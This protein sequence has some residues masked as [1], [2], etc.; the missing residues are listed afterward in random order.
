MLIELILVL[1]FSLLIRLIFLVSKSDDDYVHLWNIYQRYK[2]KN[3]TNQDITNSV[4]DGKRGYPILHHY[5]VSLFPKKAWVVVAK[6]LN[7]TY[8]LVLIVFLYYVTNN[9]FQDK[10]LSGFTYGFWA[11][12]LFST[13]PVLFPV[14]A[15]LKAM[16][17]RVV[18]SLPVFFYLLLLFYFTETNNYLIFIPMFIFGVLIIL[19]SQFAFQFF[20]LFNIVFSIFTLNF[21]PLYILIFIL[22]LAFLFPKLGIKDIISFKIAHIKWYLKSQEGTSVEKRNKVI[23]IFLLPKYLFLNVKRFLKIVFYDNSY[24][25][26][27]LFFPLI[28]YLLVYYVFAIDIIKTPLI[29]YIDEL[30]LS[31]LIIFFLT[32]HRPLIILGEAERYLEFLSPFVSIYFVY[33]LNIG[34]E[35]MNNLMIFL[36]IH[37]SI[38]MLSF[39]VS[40]RKTILNNFKLAPNESYYTMIDYLHKQLNLNILTIPIKDSFRIS[41]DLP[42]NNYYYRHINQDNTGFDYFSKETKN[43]SVPIDN[44]YYFYERYS[45]DTVIVDKEFLSQLKDSDRSK[46]ILIFENTN[47][48][49]YKYH[50]S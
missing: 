26:V 30:I 43:L 34:V 6:T 32:S 17:G 38:I 50:D 7:I 16:G 24:I 9:V 48:L 28:I 3:L 12:L 19:L 41:V 25:N 27:I 15:R 1:V 21:F 36:L 39:I 42:E 45:I 46:F 49:I 31:T 23:E 47:Y 14:T 44:W 13:M 18:G 29:Q 11:I 33:L 40:N 10:T 8:E 37:I 5:F 2:L 22:I 20:F 4:I 35:S